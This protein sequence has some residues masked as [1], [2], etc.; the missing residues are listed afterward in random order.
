[1]A[2]P[3][4]N[5]PRTSADDAPSSEMYLESF[6]VTFCGSFPFLWLLQVSRPGQRL[7]RVSCAALAPGQPQRNSSTSHL[8]DLSSELWVLITYLCAVA[9]MPGS[10]HNTPDRTDVGWL[11]AP[12]SLEK[13]QEHLGLSDQHLK[14]VNALK[15]AQMRLSLVTSLRYPEG[16]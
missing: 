13:P 1:M 15:L 8:I 9:G 10:G 14:D 2:L 6:S 11:H 5:C 12:L 4:P 3:V 7:P 16:S